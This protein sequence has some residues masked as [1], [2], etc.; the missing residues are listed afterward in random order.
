MA[1]SDARNTFSLG[2]DVSNGEDGASER[3]QLECFDYRGHQLHSP[4]RSEE[5]G[6]GCKPV[7]AENGRRQVKRLII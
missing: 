5:F 2:D 1:L 7:C 6:N 4:L 3:L